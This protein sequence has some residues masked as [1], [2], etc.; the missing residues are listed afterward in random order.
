MIFTFTNKV[1]F[2]FIYNSSEWTNILS[3]EKN[4]LIRPMFLLV[5]GWAL[6]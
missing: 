1:Y 2:G 5:M 3:N 6:G 4:L